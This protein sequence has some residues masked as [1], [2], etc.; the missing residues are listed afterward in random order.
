MYKWARFG[1]CVPPPVLLAPPPAY[2]SCFCPQPNRNL[3]LDTALA[4]AQ[5]LLPAYVPRTTSSS[6]SASRTPIPPP[7]M[8]ANDPATSQGRGITGTLLTAWR[9]RD[10]RSTSIR[11]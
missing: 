5:S 9:R 10:V 1:A 6:N 7:R 4:S 8:L 3:C 11:L 2:A